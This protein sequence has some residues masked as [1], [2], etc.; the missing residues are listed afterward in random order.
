M[1]G[2]VSNFHS[3][4]RPFTQTSESRDP[5]QDQVKVIEMSS[6]REVIEFACRLRALC[7]QVTLSDNT[8]LIQNVGD[9]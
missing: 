7:P 5:S 9:F 6:E 1:A 8:A 2:T 4:E 3:N